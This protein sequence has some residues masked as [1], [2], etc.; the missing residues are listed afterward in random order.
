MDNLSVSNVYA[1]VIYQSIVEAAAITVITIIIATD[2]VTT[3]TTTETIMDTI[4]TPDIATT[5]LIITSEA[6]TMTKKIP[7][8]RFRTEDLQDTPHKL[9]E[10]I[11]NHK[12]GTRK[13][14]TVETTT[15]R[16]LTAS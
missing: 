6:T 9:Q 8:Y 7:A 11:N 4:T 3:D 15:K 10:E 5:K 14:P 13:S 16:T 2:S 1:L 12:H